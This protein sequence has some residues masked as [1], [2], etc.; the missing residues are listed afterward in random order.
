L[1]WMQC[2]LTPQPAQS[3]PPQSTS[4]SVPFCTRSVHLGTKHVPLEQTSLSQSSFVVHVLPGAHFAHIVP[5]QSISDSPEFLMPS[6]H[7]AA[8]HTPVVHGRSMQSEFCVQC[9][10]TPHGWQ[11]GP[12]STSVSC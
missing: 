1:P 9:L 11:P 4:V 5:P 7:D 2:C 12:Q 3:I 8:W 10:P 6:A